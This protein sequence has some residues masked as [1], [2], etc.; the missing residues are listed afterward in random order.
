MQKIVLFITCEHAE[1]A[2]PSSYD[3]LF[4]HDKD[5][6]ASHFGFDIGAFTIYRALTQNFACFSVAA[7]WS[8]LLVELNRSVHHPKLFSQQ[9]LKLTKEQRSTLLKRYYW[10][11]R[12]YIIEA[13]RSATEQGFS[14]VHIAVHSFTP[15]LNNEM[16]NADIGIL[17][18][19]KR[20]FERYV[21][22]IWKNILALDYDV[23]LNYPYRGYHDGLTTTLRT[24]FSS[25]QYIGIE[26]ECNQKFFYQNN[27]ETNDLAQ[28]IIKSL[29]TVLK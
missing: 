19:P 25:E 24:L 17:Y 22:Y 21:S 9:T 28:R 6:L 7:S 27:E 4:T 3:Y 8:R 11:Y 18:D 2:I 13:L 29:I 5:L 23:R 15:F 26:L 1:N 20:P 10:P 12:S 16:R 14:V